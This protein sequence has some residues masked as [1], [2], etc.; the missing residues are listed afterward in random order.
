MF[1]GGSYPDLIWALAK[2]KMVL[3]TC[4]AFLVNDLEVGSLIVNTDGDPRL[5]RWPGGALVPTAGDAGR[6]IEDTGIFALLRGSDYEAIH[7]YVTF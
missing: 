4:F 5:V 6:P 3:A 7:V 1:S 2:L